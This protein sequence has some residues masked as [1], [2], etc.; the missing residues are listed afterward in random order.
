MHNAETA[1]NNESSHTG[2]GALIVGTLGASALGIYTPQRLHN[3]LH[4]SHLFGLHRLAT[5]LQRFVLIYLHRTLRLHRLE[6]PQRCAAG[7]QLVYLLQAAILQLRY[8]EEYSNNHRDVDR[9]VDIAQLA[10]KVGV[11][12]ID[13]VWLC[14]RGYEGGQDGHHYRQQGCLFLD[15]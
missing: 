4:L 2:E 6:L 10:T 14:K 1:R 13:E 5:F 15:A 8:N 9:A 7:K 12:R 11:F 3:I